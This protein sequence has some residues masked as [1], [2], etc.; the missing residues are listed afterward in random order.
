MCVTNCVNVRK[1]IKSTAKIFFTLAVILTMQY[2][3]KTTR[4]LTVEVDPMKCARA[5]VGKNYQLE[6]YPLT[7]ANVEDGGEGG[8]SR[9]GGERGSRRVGG[10][11]GVFA[12]L[13]SVS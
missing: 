8:S 7:A 10:A 3:Q 9:V 13:D 4:L 2:E 12:G 1:C 5:R 11:T 6:Q